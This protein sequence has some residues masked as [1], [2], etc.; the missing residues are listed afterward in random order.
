MLKEFRWPGVPMLN[1][2]QGGNMPAVGRQNRATILNVL[3]RYG[4]IS[5]REMCQITGLTSGAITNIV[6]DLLASDLA[7]EVGSLR[8]PEGRGVGRRRVLV[9]LKPGG[10]FAVGVHLGVRSVIVALGDLRGKILRQQAFPT[11]D[12]RAPYAVLQE[13]V[14]T[15]SAVIRESGVDRGKLLGVGVGCAGL[16]DPRSGVLK[17]MLHHRWHEVDVAGYL[18]SALGLPVAVENNRNAMAVAE[19]TFGQAQKVENFLLVHVGTTIGSGVVIDRK[20]HHGSNDAAGQIG[21]LVLEPEGPLCSCGLRGCLDALAS[22]AAIV[23]QALRGFRSQSSSPASRLRASGDGQF[24]AEDLFGAALQGDEE[25]RTLVRTAGRYLGRGIGQAA[26]I[27]S[28]ELV[29]VVG[30]IFQTGDLVMAPLREAA[31]SDAVR[32]MGVPV[33]VVPTSFG[34][35]LRVVGALSLALQQFLYCAQSTP[36]ADNNGAS[37]QRQAPLLVEARTVHS[38]IAS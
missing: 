8:N 37:G 23:R 7:V 16:V 30:S 21:H 31:F 32:V 19:S 22:E 15:I 9:D 25:A 26:K 38:G 24:Q 18:G 10:A 33:R 34:L 13:M 27:L 35:E 17:S 36:R 20:V 3:L 14:E 29:I 1:S 4:P 28:P 12:G 6:G 11:G 5:R 2:L